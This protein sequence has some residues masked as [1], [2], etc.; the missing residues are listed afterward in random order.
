MMSRDPNLP[1][2][3]AMSW[4]NDPKCP[5]FEWLVNYKGQSQDLNPIENW[6][7]T[8]KQGCQMV[9]NKT[10]TTPTRKLESVGNEM[11]I[12]NGWKELGSKIVQISNWI[13]N[14]EAQP[15]EIGPYGHHFVKNHLKLGQKCPVFKWFDSIAKAGL[16]EILPLKSPD[17]RS[18]LQPKLDR[19]L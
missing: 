2:I 16:F 19:D 8:R 4:K 7:Q 18:P 10:K 1:K 11:G 13:W 12:W 15:L 3:E 14:L 5:D 6:T 9:F 17:F